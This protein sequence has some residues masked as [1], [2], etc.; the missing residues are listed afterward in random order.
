MYNYQSE[1]FIHKLTNNFTW[2][3]VVKLFVP[4]EKP[5]KWKGDQ[6]HKANSNKHVSCKCCK[7][8]S[9]WEKMRE[10]WWKQNQW[11]TVLLTR[12]SVTGYLPFCTQVTV[13]SKLSVL[14]L[15]T[16]FTPSALKSLLSVILNWSCVTSSSL[17]VKV[18]LIIL[19]FLLL[20]NKFCNFS[21][22]VWNLDTAGILIP[23]SLFLFINEL[24]WK[25]IW[26]R[27]KKLLKTMHIRWFCL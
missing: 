8:Q 1:D 2:L 10:I 15:S 5:Q 4:V 22:T 12:N 24:E 27:V 21:K 17:Q 20:S 3:S 7:V 23:S 9:L 19:S 25:S 13:Q 16:C 11:K 6:K 26:L 18:Y 14:K